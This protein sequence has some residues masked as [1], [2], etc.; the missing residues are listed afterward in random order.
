MSFR[1]VGRSSSHFTRTT[2]VVAHEC[3]VAYDFQA[4]PD[5]MSRASGE[6]ADN[7][8]LK[9]P[10]LQT[11]DGPWFGALNCC[12]ELARHAPGARIVWPEALSRLASNAQ[13]LVLQGMATEVT[14]IMR[15]Q[16]A[17]SEYDAKLRNSLDNTLAWLDSQLPEA[18]A[19][20]KPDRTVS[21][22]EVSAFCFVTHLEFRQMADIQP[23][24][25]LQQFC[26]AF[27]ERP[28]ARD[29]TYRFDR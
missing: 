13:E 8:A 16:S 15:G 26:Q 28:A 9:L 22:L 24:S 3:G 18:L 7:P 23:Y 27:S 20:L 21:F 4:V 14:L 29:T 19:T 6:Y 11:P 12:R 1:I 10:I 25:A 2:R 17:A 5:L